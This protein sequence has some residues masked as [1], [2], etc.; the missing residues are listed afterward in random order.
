MKNL[1]NTA[2]SLLE[3]LLSTV[4]FVITI[5]GIFATLNAVRGPVTSKEYALSSAVFGKQV[6]ETLRNQVSNGSS[7][8]FYTVC[9]ASAPYCTTFD[10]A[11]GKH[12]VT[13]PS[14]GLNWP[15]LLSSNNSTLNYTVSCADGSATCGAPNSYVARR[16]DLKICS[17][18]T[19]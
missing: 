7:A 9:P 10:L 18:A 14:S 3:I 2:F 1:N 13:L 17:D 12:Q 4:I 11:L 5:G 16:V 19:C 6:F 15:T 8:N